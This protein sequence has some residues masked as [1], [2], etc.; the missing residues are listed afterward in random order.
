MRWANAGNRYARRNGWRVY[1]V[2]LRGHGD[3]EWASDG[4]Y[5]LDALSEDVLAISDE[6][7]VFRNGRKV[8][9]SAVGEIDKAWLIHRMIGRGHEELEESYT[10]EI[11]LESREQAPVVLQTEGLTR[12]GAFEGVSLEVRKGE[13]LGVY[14]FMGS[15]QLELARTLFGNDSTVIRAGITGR[16][17]RARRRCG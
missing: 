14:G 12:A 9:E 4:D 6:V 3:S 5:T 8:G 17:P 1:S 2:D 7:T 11:Q 13:V 15:G 10:G 16:S